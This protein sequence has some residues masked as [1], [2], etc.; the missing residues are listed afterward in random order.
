MALNSRCEETKVVVLGKMAI[1][2][3]KSGGKALV[4]SHN[5]CVLAK[6]LG[7]CFENYDC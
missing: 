7:L 4:G 1:I 2:K 6:R 5:L 3:T